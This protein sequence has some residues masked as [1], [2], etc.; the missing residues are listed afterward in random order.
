MHC[1]VDFGMPIAN[2]RLHRRSKNHVVISV[3]VF[4]TRATPGTSAFL[5]NTSLFGRP[6]L[7]PFH[8]PLPFFFFLNLLV[9]FMYT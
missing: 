8:I 6:R 4:F 3:L 7:H 5:L 1:M 9:L 2:L